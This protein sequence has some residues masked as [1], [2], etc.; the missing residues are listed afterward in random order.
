VAPSPDAASPPSRPRVAI[1]CQGGGSHAAFT[2]GALERLLEPDLVRRYELVALSG[3]SGGAVC[4]A[5][6]WAGLVARGAG[7]GS[8]DARMRLYE[9]WR[10]L[11]AEGI[12][13]G[14]V[15]A[16]T[17]AA[18][19]MPGVADFTPQPFISP[20]EASLRHLLQKHVRLEELSPAARAR[21]PELF[22][23]A[24]DVLRGERRVFR[25]GELILDELVASAAVPRLFRA[26]PVGD[27][28]YW[29]GLFSCNPPIRELT[30][31]EPVPDEIWVIRLNPRRRA[32][33]PLVLYDVLDR[34]NEL[35]GNLSLDEELASVT[36]MN[37]LREKF[38]ELRARYQ[39]IVVREIELDAE[40]L[41]YA[42]K[43]D[44]SPELLDRLH[45]KG[46]EKA[47]DLVG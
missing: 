32:R 43:L 7:G 47:A 31:L 8:G 17:V 44:R 2:A 25:G 33:P 46:R 9:F 4:A 19:R 12:F 45:A 1:A 27:S 13:D 5:L 38:P 39:P 10:E 35:A 28:V 30:D 41:D 6:A 21:G 36:R 20:A 14:A 11:A 16:F 42:S 26:I 22:V 34:M 18:S 37:A 24:T 29:D 23:G 3:T 15:N 40:G